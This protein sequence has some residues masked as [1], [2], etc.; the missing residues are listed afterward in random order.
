MKITIEQEA[1]KAILRLC[2]RFDFAARQLFRD[3][4]SGPLSAIHVYEL[5]I[6]LSALESLDDTALGFLL[7]LREKCSAAGKT[8]GIVNCPRK[9]KE[10]LQTT[11][12]FTIN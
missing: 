2:G 3:A 4:Y 12:F 8:V 7:I 6:D 9:I 11:R 5:Q 1:H 10:K